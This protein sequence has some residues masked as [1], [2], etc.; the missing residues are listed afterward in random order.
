MPKIPSLILLSLFFSF[1]L[2]QGQEFKLIK[3]EDDIQIFKRDVKES[4]LHEFRAVT[5]INSSVSSL[6]AL[7]SDAESFPKWMPSCTEARTIKKRTPFS[8]YNYIVNKAPWPMKNRDMI[9]FSRL[10]ANP[11]TKSVKI[12]MKGVKDYLPEKK[13][14]VRV[15]EL[16]GFWQFTPMGDGE[17]EVIYQIFTDPGGKVPAM[18]VNTK[19]GEMPFITIKNMKKIIMEEKYQT[20]RFGLIKDEGGEE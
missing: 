19:S 15:A 14:L 12:K 17:T 3:N 8:R 10:T 20:A 13:G 4:N 1:T 16:K 11:L 2:I 5:K 7:M 6:I 18:L 9:V